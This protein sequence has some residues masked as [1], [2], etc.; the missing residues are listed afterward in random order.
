M[1]GD[2]TPSFKA[3]AEAFTILAKYDNESPEITADHDEIWFGVAGDA[4]S[5]SDRARINELGFE[6]DPGGGFHIFI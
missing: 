4:I 5:D 2:T 1:A 6:S 3:W